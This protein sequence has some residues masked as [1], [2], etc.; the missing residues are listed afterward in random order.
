MSY[1]SSVFSNMANLIFITLPSSIAPYGQNVQPGIAKGSV[2]K[3][4][5]SEII[6]DNIQ[7]KYGSLDQRAF[8]NHV[9]NKADRCRTFSL[10]VY[11]QT[12]TQK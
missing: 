12:L 5:K 1:N 8:K 10:K 9:M 11:N 4:K 2:D 3:H 7:T 6:L